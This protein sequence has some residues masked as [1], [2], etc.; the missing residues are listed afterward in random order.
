MTKHF[1]DF[2]YNFNPTNK[3]LRFSEY[4]KG[5]DEYGQLFQDLKMLLL[6]KHDNDTEKLNISDIILTKDDIKNLDLDKLKKLE[7]DEK[8]KRSIGMSFD[9]E[10]LKNGDVRFYNLDNIDKKSRPWE[11]FIEN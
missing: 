2:L 6:L 9:F 4:R 10:F 7:N 3:I 5:S 11:N 1:E 8:T